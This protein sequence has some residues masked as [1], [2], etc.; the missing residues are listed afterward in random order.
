M[1]TCPHVSANMELYFELTFM[2]KVFQW[3]LNGNTCK[4]TACTAR[5]LIF[6]WLYVIQIFSVYKQVNKFLFKTELN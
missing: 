2:D 3:R 6:L 1:E 4:M 5:Q